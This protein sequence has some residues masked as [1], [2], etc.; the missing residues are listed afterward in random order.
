M[1]K[2]KKIMAAGDFPEYSRREFIRSGMSLA[3]ERG[4]RRGVQDDRKR[5]DARGNQT[6]GKIGKV[7]EAYDFPEY[8]PREFFHAGMSLALERGRRRSVQADRERTDAR[9]ARP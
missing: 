2:I 4:Q 5:T 6:M 1:G 8:S 9:R 3:L 7:L